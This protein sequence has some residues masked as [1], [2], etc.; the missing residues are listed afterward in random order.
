M[1][2]T[3]IHGLAAAIAEAW[4]D[5]LAL[6]QVHQAHLHSGV[7]YPEHDWDRAVADVLTDRA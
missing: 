5:D 3:P 1:D 2:E 4:G 7:D 6:E